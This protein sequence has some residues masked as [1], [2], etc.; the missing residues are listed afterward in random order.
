ML[1]T[2]SILAVL[3]VSTAMADTKYECLI[4]PSQMVEI[5][6]PITGLLDSVQVKRGERVSKGQ[7][8]AHLESSADKAAT[9]LALF[10]SEMKGSILSA[11]NKTEFAKR[12]FQRRQEMALDE[13]MSAQEKEDAE[14]ELKLAK[15]ELQLAKENKQLAKIEWQQQ[16]SLL[17][18]RTIHSPF[19]GVVVEQ[20]LFPGEIAEPNSDKK[21]I[22]K[23]ANI[24]TLH[25]HVI[26]PIALFNKVKVGNSVKITSEYPV[27]GQYSG[28]VAIADRVIN[29]SSGTFSVFVKLQNPKHEIPAGIKCRVAF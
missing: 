25:A 10:K 20:L 7:V 12:K 4:E 23:L 13:L 1:F 9:E 3:H 21:P 14:I 22:F 6:S 18:L 17:N 27:N 24:S 29:A 5:R 8:I 2:S 28:K 11:E 16:N 15:S 26:L 19:D